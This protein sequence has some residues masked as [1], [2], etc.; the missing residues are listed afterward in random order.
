MRQINDNAGPAQAAQ[1]PRYGPSGLRGGLDVYADLTGDRSGIDVHDLR[2]V[3]GATSFAGRL[4]V[5]APDA[6]SPEARPRVDLDLRASDIVIDEFLPAQRRTLPQRAASPW[7]D[8]P[9]WTGALTAVDGAIGLSATAASLGPHRIEEPVLSVTLDQG[10]ATVTHATGRLFGGDVGLTGSIGVTTDP[11]PRL[12]VRYDLDMVDFDVQT[13][14]DRVFE[15][16]GVS[17]RGNFGLTGTA[18]GASERDLVESLTGE[19]LIAMRDGTIAG[20]DLAG[21]DQLLDTPSEPVAF[22]GQ[23]RDALSGGHTGYDALNARFR[24]ENGVLETESLRLV[25][26]AGF[27]EGAGTFSLPQWRL[28]LNTDFALYDHPEAPPVGIAL[29]GRPELLTRQLQTLA[30]QAFVAQQAA[31]A[32]T[33][34]FTAPVAPATGPPAPAVGVGPR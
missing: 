3:V 2:G 21:L 23:L 4:G 1:V 32:L 22:I 16:G 27:G 11:A 29:G 17:G 13:V 26:P 9:L 28:D 24:V 7:S 14:L 10:T 34:R 6:E 15:T 18:S 33:D 8:A 30:V 12:D 31:E 25:T 5:A 19:G 20:F